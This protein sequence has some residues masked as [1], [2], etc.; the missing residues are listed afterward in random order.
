MMDF[1]LEDILEDL[2]DF[3]DNTSVEYEVWALGYN[4]ED[5]ATDDDVHLNSFENHEEAVEYAKNVTWALVA[6]HLAEESTVYVRVQVETVVEDPDDE[7]T[8][9]IGTIY[10]NIICKE[11]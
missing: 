9:N 1:G 11:V 4:D 7:G 10:E 5:E 3:P 8:M 6:G 2:E